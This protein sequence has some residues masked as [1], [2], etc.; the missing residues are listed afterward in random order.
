MLETKVDAFF[1]DLY[2]KRAALTSEQ[3]TKLEAWQARIKVLQK[4]W[5][6]HS[7]GIWLVNGLYRAI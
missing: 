4:I 6:Q 3:Q 2:Y 5:A 7:R 1:Q